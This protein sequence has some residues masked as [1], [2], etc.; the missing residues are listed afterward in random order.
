METKGPGA[1]IGNKN[2]EKWTYEEAEKLFNE[3]AAMARKDEYDFIGEIASD[4]GTNRHILSELADKFP[5]LK[6]I[7]NQIL[8][9][10]EANCF[11]HAKKGKI[12][13]ATAIVNLKSNYKWKDRADITTGEKPLPD[14]TK[15][16]IVK[17]VLNDTAGES[18]S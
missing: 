11:R 14:I 4:L 5:D 8:S 3:A 13:E 1:P 18:Q 10:L 17:T 2:A 16:E 6:P 12:K 7:H 15:I 9:T